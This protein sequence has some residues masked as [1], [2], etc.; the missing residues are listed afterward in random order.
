[1]G[2]ELISSALSGWLMTYNAWIAMFLGWAIMLS[3]IFAALLL[4]ETKNAIPAMT[5]ATH[6]THELPGWEDGAEPGVPRPNWMPN[7]DATGKLRSKSMSIF[8]AYGFILK[9][10]QMML[11]LSSFLIYKLSRGIGWF[12]LQYISKRYD[13]TLAKATF[14]MS[15]KAAVNIVLFVAILPGLSWYL[16]EKR[17]VNSRVKDM[18]LTKFSAVLMIVGT[19]AMGLSPS[20]AGMI[21]GLMVQTLGGGFV[22]LT[23]SLITTMV[24][25]EQ[26]ARLYTIIE[27]LQAFGMILAGPIIAAFFNWGLELGGGWIGLP[28]FVASFLFVLT[29]IVVWRVQLPPQNPTD[30]HSGRNG[31]A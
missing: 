15:F 18:Q 24:R 29:A 9:D 21:A 1:M 6:P 17:H 5:K 20:A 27:L 13:W 14:L 4:P 16:M 2:S 7:G 23:R 12:Q 28:F 10:N 30:V 3:G 19:A 26:T 8:R 11:L 31:V 22:F 25:P